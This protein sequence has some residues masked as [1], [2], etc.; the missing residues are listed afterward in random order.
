MNKNLPAKI[1][2]M[3][4]LLEASKVS[5]AKMLRKRIDIDQFVKIAVTAASKNPKLLDCDKQSFLIAIMDAAQMGLEPDGPMK[6]GNLI[7][8]GNKV[9]FMPQYFGLLQILY[10]TNRL[11]HVMCDVVREGDTFQYES[12]FGEN[13][14]LRHIRA[15]GPEQPATFVYAGVEMKDGTRFLSVM[16]AEEVEQVRKNYSKESNSKA[17]TKSW[18]EMAKKTVIKRLYKML[19]K[20]KALTKAIDIDNE[21]NFDLDKER[22]YPE[23]PR[24]KKCPGNARPIDQEPCSDWTPQEEPIDVSE[25]PEA[26]AE[27]VQEDSTTDDAKEAALIKSLE[28]ECKELAEKIPIAVEFY[29]QKIESTA[30]KGLDAMITLKDKWELTLRKNQEEGG[31]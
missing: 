25:T 3:Q 16:T 21:Y 14:Q 18:G 20:T 5:I 30:E 2:D 17:W 23:M 12:G 13:I 26:A 29:V 27:A 6:H 24:A 15:A 4:V 10:D 11:K 1:T 8:F 31:E 28:K 9:V 19:P 7:P 22:T